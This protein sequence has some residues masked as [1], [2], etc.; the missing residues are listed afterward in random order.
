ML[1]CHIKKCGAGTIPG[2]TSSKG[3]YEFGVGPATFRHKNGPGFVARSPGSFAPVVSCPLTWSR[4][5]FR[6]FQKASYERSD[7][8]LAALLGGLPARPL[9]PWLTSS[10]HGSNLCQLLPATSHNNWPTK[11]KW[12]GCSAHPLSN[13][14]RNKQTLSIVKERMRTN[15]V[16]M[17]IIR[18][19][20]IC[21]TLNGQ[22]KLNCGN[23][24]L[25]LAK[26][27]SAVPTALIYDC[28]NTNYSV[29]TKRKRSS[30]S[31]EHRQTN[32]SS[33]RSTAT[34][35]DG[36]Q[37]MQRGT[38]TDCNKGTSTIRDFIHIAPTFSQ[39][40]PPSIEGNSSRKNCQGT[41][42]IVSLLHQRICPG[43]TTTTRANVL[44]TANLCVIG[45]TVMKGK[46]CRPTATQSSMHCDP[47]LALFA[48]QDSER[49]CTA[50]PF[51]I[52][53]ASTT[54][55]SVSAVNCDTTAIIS[56]HVHVVTKRSTNYQCSKSMHHKFSRQLRPNVQSKRLDVSSR[57][58]KLAKTSTV[59]PS[60]EQRN[61]RD[62]LYRAKTCPNIPC[63]HF[64]P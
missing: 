56:K 15:C 58:F 61:H 44:K 47:A 52:N 4:Y 36:V 30:T 26:H 27:I 62:I 24:P 8:K 64:F 10:C 34:L 19:R 41:C 14:C 37:W 51:M 32:K 25:E 12:H 16:I 31:C 20:T 6:R 63:M 23:G 22:S 18:R 33:C 11:S 29:R 59:S 60:L 48:W 57:H 54:P 53:P 49:A 35:A 50:G 5:P 3:Y 43:H 40:K 17:C 55:V 46:S 42:I 45:T 38:G 1:S 9:V 21:N 28:N 2:T 7:P 39:N 13:K